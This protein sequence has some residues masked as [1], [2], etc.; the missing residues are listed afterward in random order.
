MKDKLATAAGVAL[1][2]LFS[3]TIGL[4]LGYLVLTHMAGAL[5]DPVTP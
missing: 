2:M 4:V 1:L 5:E 3:S